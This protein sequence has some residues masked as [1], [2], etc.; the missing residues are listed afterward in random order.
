KNYQNAKPTEKIY[1]DL[2]IPLRI[3]RD[4][5]DEDV[6]DVIVDDKTTQVE[7]YKFV[8]TIAPEYAQRVHYYAGPQDLFERFAINKQIQE[9]LS[10][11]V[12]LR[13]GGSIIIEQT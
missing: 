3:V 5:L 7:V 1:E 12:N 13:S 2:P 11:K 9:A 8:K 6:E 4:H 10:Q